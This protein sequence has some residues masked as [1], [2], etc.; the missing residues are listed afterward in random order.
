[1]PQN[2][3]MKQFAQVEKLHPVLSTKSDLIQ[4]SLQGIAQRRQK[5]V[6][7]LKSSAAK[8]DST[9]AI[10]NAQILAQ[11]AVLALIVEK[12]FAGARD[13]LM[14]KQLEKLGRK[15]MEH[16]EKLNLIKE[17]GKKLNEKKRF[18][19]ILANDKIQ[20][21]EKEKQKGLFEENRLA[22]EKL[23]F[24]LAL[25][26][27]ELDAIEGVSSHPIFRNEPLTH[28][29]TVHDNQLL[30]LKDYEKREDGGYDATMKQPD[31]SVSVMPFPSLK[32]F[33]EFMDQDLANVRKLTDGEGNLRI[34]HDTDL[35]LLEKYTN[36][37][38]NGLFILKEEFEPLKFKSDENVLSDIKGVLEEKNKM[39]LEE[40]V[41]GVEKTIQKPAN[42]LKG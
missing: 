6:D 19:Q 21:E 8:M 28:L 16:T 37:D 39:T 2:I 23:A 9:N 33:V 35:A 13:Y 14:K 4:Q 42:T 36:Q 25:S 29:D 10:R 7:D 22:I 12:L 20:E 40:T 41:N 24:D 5:I 27:E 31:G 34:D 38:N 3:R 30:V 18:D 26:R 11:Y 15:E 1:M 32:L 17:L